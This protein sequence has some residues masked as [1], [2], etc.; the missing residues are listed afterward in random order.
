MFRLLVMT[1]AMVL[2]L[3]ACRG[4]SSPSGGSSSQSGSASGKPEGT[5]SDPVTVCERFGDVC[6]LDGSRLGVCAAQ[7]QGP[8]LV[9]APQH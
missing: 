1:S 6:K 3:G 7:K 8:G 4:G 9:C 2:A 5:T